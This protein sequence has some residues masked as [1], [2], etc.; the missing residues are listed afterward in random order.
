MQSRCERDKSL[1]V[2]STFLT[3]WVYSRT[4]LLSHMH[5]YNAKHDTLEGRWTV[6]QV[7]P[8][9]LIMGHRINVP[10]P[11][12][13]VTCLCWGCYGGKLLM[14]KAATDRYCFPACIQTFSIYS[15]LNF[16]GPPCRSLRIEFL[17]GFLAARS[18]QLDS[19]KN[20]GILLK[21]KCPEWTLL[22]QWY[23]AMKK[24]WT[25]CSLGRCLCVRSC[26]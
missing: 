7:L 4:L 1:S 13:P 3:A 20:A 22:Q 6:Q 21:A 16:K 17:E 12:N 5:I 25:I 14:N 23:E 8:A 15:N 18:L 26:I 24:W 11:M 10:S 19:S 9:D 2:S